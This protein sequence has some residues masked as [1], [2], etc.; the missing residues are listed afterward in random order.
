MTCALRQFQSRA[1]RVGRVI[2]NPPPQELRPRSGRVEVSA[3]D[4]RFARV[5][6]SL[7]EGGFTLIELMIVIGLIILLVGGLSVS[8][9]DT[10]GSSLSSA[11]NLVGSLVGT[12]RAQAA[13]NQTQA[14]VAVYATQPPTGD[15]EK[16]LRLVQVF[17]LNQAT[18]AWAPVGSPAYLPRGVYVVPTTAPSGANLATGVGAWMASPSP[19]STFAAGVL[20]AQP[21]GTAFGGTPQVL[22]LEFGPEGSVFPATPPYNK[23]VVAT[24]ALSSTNNNRPTFTNPGA[25]RGVII[26]PNGAVSFVNDATS[27]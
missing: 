20:T 27:F 8:L 14:R 6:R 7:G 10:A 4:L 13:V 25:V 9:R 17:V 1:A 2:L 3:P 16:Y 26:R 18:N 23:F 22:Y 21:A 15:P 5:R 12:A 11:Q 24:A 19:V